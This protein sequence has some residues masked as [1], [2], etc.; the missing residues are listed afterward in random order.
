MNEFIFKNL[1]SDIINSILE[2]T[3]KLYYHKGK[4]IG[5]LDISKYGILNKVQ[6]PIKLPHNA[7]NL[8]L[9]N[10][11]NKKGYILRYIIC[12]DNII[13]LSV[14]YCKGIDYTSTEYFIIPKSSPKWRRVQSYEIL[15]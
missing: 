12:P 9:F 3:G 2:F 8:Y 4:Y 14:I 13:R 10:D 6:K 1:P 7:Y 5:K 15:S 11:I